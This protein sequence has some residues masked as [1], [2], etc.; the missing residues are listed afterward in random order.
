M[1]RYALPRAVT[2]AP[3]V[4]CSHYLPT[5]KP[6]DSDRPGFVSTSTSDLDTA[7]AARENSVS[8]QFESRSAVML[9]VVTR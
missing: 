7:I 2:A 9:C 8:F 4:M 3:I 5:D 1:G 6:R